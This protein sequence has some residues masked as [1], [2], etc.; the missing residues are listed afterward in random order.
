MGGN[1]GNQNYSALRQI[2]KGR[3]RKLG[4]AWINHIEGGLTTGNNQST[5]VVVDGTIYIESAPG[6]VVA[7]D[8]KT[9]VTR[10]KYTQT[11]GNLTRRGV[12]VGQGLVYT[13]S[14]DNYVVALD[15]NTGAVVWERQHEGFGNVEKVAVVYFDGKLLI[16]TNDGDRGAALAMNASNGDLLWHFWGAPGPGEF[17]NDTWEGDSWQEGGATPWI[18]P[19]IDPDLGWCSSRSAM[20]APAPRRMAPRAAATTCSRTRSSRSTSKPAPTNG[21]SSPFTTTSGTWTT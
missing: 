10:W 4:A 12:A 11:R 17:G 13:L 2:N 19:A 14:G 3:I 18:H 7:V 15:Q 21:I 5:P 8:G 1:L 20:C 6:N 9:G 16:G